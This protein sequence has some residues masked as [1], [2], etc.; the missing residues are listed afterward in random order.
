MS[1]FERKD[2]FIIV[3]SLR[4]HIS[5]FHS[6]LHYHNTY[7]KKPESLNIFGF[8]KAVYISGKHFTCGLLLHSIMN[9]SLGWQFKLL[10]NFCGVNA[11]PTLTSSC[12]GVSLNWECHLTAKPLLLAGACFSTPL[13]LRTFQIST[14]DL[15][16]RNLICHRF[17][18][19]QK[20]K[21]NC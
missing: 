11:P 7:F 12:Q 17:S 20:Q 10:A 4:F 16:Q 6:Y 5:F 14:I 9:I 2:A 19:S 13:P 8:C 18:E 15:W 3:S 1:H 21:P